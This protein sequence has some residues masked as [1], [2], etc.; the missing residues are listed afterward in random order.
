MVF[1]NL[2]FGECGSSIGL[3]TA[4]SFYV[5]LILNI[6]C[7]TFSRQKQCYLGF[8]CQHDNYSSCIVD[9]VFATAGS[10]KTDVTLALID[11]LTTFICFKIK[12]F[13]HCGRQSMSS[14]FRFIHFLARNNKF[15]G[16]IL[17]YGGCFLGSLE[18]I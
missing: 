1:H 2:F 8:V 6:G 13:S 7:K 3:I 9:N 4:I 12:A 15:K 17:I 10:L 11:L 5:D 16:I 18:R 14:C